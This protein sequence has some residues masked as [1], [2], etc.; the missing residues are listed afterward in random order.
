MTM[1]LILCVI[2]YM[3]ALQEHDI[4]KA[5]KCLEDACKIMRSTDWEP[6]EKAPWIC[7]HGLYRLAA[8][9]L[10]EGEFKK[11]AM[12]NCKTFRREY[13]EWRTLLGS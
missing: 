9:V 6:E 10:T 11:T 1:T 8:K 3:L 5:G 13:A 7:G 12:P 2:A 4:V